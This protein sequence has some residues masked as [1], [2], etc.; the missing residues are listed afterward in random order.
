VLSTPSI[1]DITTAFSTGADG[2][3]IPLPSG[4]AAGRVLFGAVTVN[5]SVSGV[6]AATTPSG[7]AGVQFSSGTLNALR[8]Y[9]FGKT[10]DGT[11]T[12]FISGDLPQSSVPY[13][14][15]AMIMGGVVSDAGNGST[16]SESLSPSPS[17]TVTPDSISPAWGTA[18]SSLFIT[19]MTRTSATNAVTSYPSGYIVAQGDINPTVSCRL[20]Y[21][22]KR[23]VTTTE[24]PSAWVVAGSESS[25]LTT[26]SVYR[27]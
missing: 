5:N 17:G 25:M 6:N 7:I 2:Y 4:V 22:V 26:I 1:I 10:L 21:A 27:G 23:A 11:E 20:S 15:F 8:L 18:G 16:L 24:V 19:V 9:I 3:N 12:G 13:A 14:G